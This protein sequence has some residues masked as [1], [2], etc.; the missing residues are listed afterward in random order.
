MAIFLLTAFMMQHILDNYPQFSEASI[1]NRFTSHK[2][3]E[4]LIAGLPGQF[5]KS[6]A[7]YSNNGR[8]IHLIQCGTGITRVMV[9]SQMHGDEATG[10]MAIFDLLK[11]IGQDFDPVICIELL[12]SCTLYLIP[13]LNPD[14]A[15][16]FTRRNAQQIDIN[17]DYLQRTTPEARILIELQESIKPDFAF[18]LHDQST[19]W[20]VRGTGKPASLSFLAPA[21]NSLLESNTIRA[22]A[23]KVI[24]A[25]FSVLQPHLPEHIGLFDD[26]YEER[27]FG[28]NFQRNET[29]TILI[30]AGGMQGDPEKQELRKYYFLSILAGLSAIANQSYVAHFTA[31]YFRI[32]A[33]AKEI[34][35]ILIRDVLVQ[36]FRTSIGLNYTE[37]PAGDGK[38][39]TLSYMVEDIGDLRNW[40]AY[41]LFDARLLRIDGELLF[42]KPANF[43]LLDGDKTILSFRNGILHSKR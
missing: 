24:A 41:E 33:N 8:A 11:F 38:S 35:H 5:T 43:N 30:E 36:D 18:N 2:Q 27:A 32:P 26:E 15:A 28:D 23:M 9:W 19:L 42:N 4:K 13:M 17:R 7:G 10:T 22:K 37:E 1:K 25:I 29:S 6:V 16:H 39:T 40:S 20:S 31:D 3:V 21:Y 14:G 12:R 34:F